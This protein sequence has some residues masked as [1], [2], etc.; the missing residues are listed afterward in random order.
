VK[1]V[2]HTAIALEA[3]AIYVQGSNLVPDLK[4]FPFGGRMDIRDHTYS[5][6]TQSYGLVTGLFNGHDV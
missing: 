4:A 3:T 6:V 2:Y 5:F 1:I